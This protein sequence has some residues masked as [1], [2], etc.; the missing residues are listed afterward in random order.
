LA[1]KSRD[2]PQDENKITA[3]KDE[4][5]HKMTTVSTQNFLPFRVKLIVFFAQV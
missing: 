5:I 4:Q 3:V 2:L 1:E